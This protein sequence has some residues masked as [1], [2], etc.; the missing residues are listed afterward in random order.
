M[1]AMLNAFDVSCRAVAACAAA[2][3][4]FVPLASAQGASEKVLYSFQGQPDGLYPYAGL[5]KDKAG[6]L[7]GVTIDGGTH[8]IGT[9]FEVTPGGAESVLYS[10]QG[11]PDGGFPSAGLIEDKAGN[12]YGTTGIGGVYGCGTIFEVTPSGIETVLHSFT[13]GSD[14]GVPAASLIKGNGGNFYST[15]VQGGAH[16]GGTVFEIAPTG[17]ETV[18]YSFTGG[19][20]GG[21]PAAGLVRGSNDNFYGTTAYGG[22]HDLGTLYEIT[23]SGAETVLYS[24]TGGNDGWY[25]NAP[26]VLD[27]TGDLYGTAEYGG[28]SGYGTLFKLAPDGTFTVVVA[29]AGSNGK[30]PSPGGGLIRDASGDLYGTTSGGGAYGAGTVFEVK[31][32]GKERVLYS[33]AGGTDGADPLGVVEKEHNLYGATYGGGTADAGTVFEIS[34]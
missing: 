32:T 24:F 9:V 22:T 21:V 16:N 17:S 26:L 19:N 20:D 18:L 6:N 1:P 5:I 34:R 10:F 13:G 14:G 11:E 29:F 25:P 31:A 33:F 3:A 8:G 2:L 12:L 7:Y 27:G 23:P 30:T 28:A 15:T 4:P